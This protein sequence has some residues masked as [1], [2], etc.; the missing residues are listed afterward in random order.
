MYVAPKRHIDSRRPSDDGGA[1]R[2]T[3]LRDI[4]ALRDEGYVIYSDVG[5]GAGL[6]L[7]PQSFQTTAKLSVPEV[8]ALLI[9][10]SA[11]RAAGNLTFSE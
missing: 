1:S 6:Q 2:R 7:E 11:V 5:T 8:F 4:S 10:V 3:V 9:S